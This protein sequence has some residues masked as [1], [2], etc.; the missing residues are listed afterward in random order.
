VV[1]IKRNRAANREHRHLRIYLSRETR[2][3]FL[4]LTIAKTAATMRLLF[5]DVVY[6][7]TG[8]RGHRKTV[9]CSN[10]CRK[11]LSG[12]KNYST[13]FCSPRRWDSWNGEAGR[14]KSPWTISGQW[15][16]SAVY[17]V[18]ESSSPQVH[19]LFHTIHAFLLMAS[20]KRTTRRLL[21]KRGR[22]G[23]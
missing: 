8:F 15:Y 10:I 21:S 18:S 13:L 17:N 2:T 11:E 19:R 22:K 20:R 5:T 4:S 3:R 16:S 6:P 14:I 9:C 1:L 23:K 12:R 7:S